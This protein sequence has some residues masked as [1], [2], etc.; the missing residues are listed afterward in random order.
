MITFSHR[1]RLFPD[2]PENTLDSFVNLNRKKGGSVEFDV[3][4]TKD[5]VLVIVHD[6]NTKR[7][8]DKNL[9]ISKSDYSE[10]SKIK[11]LKH[12]KIP[13]LLECLDALSDM[14]II[15]I[16][17]KQKKIAKELNELLINYFRNNP[18]FKPKILISSRLLTEIRNINLDERIQT[19]L[20]INFSALVRLMLLKPRPSIIIVN[21][22]FL[23]PILLKYCKKKSIN[24][25]CYT[26]NKP[27]EF[28]RL[29]ELKV[30]GLYTDNYN[31]LSNL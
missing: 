2:D 24:I 1:G 28:E 23:N 4:K 26:V 25:F 10:I 14:N 20:I 21:R 16:E 15:N 12:Y 7:L 27:N 6:K 29:K 8:S 3:R 17:I 19:G 22:F 31:M 13:T 18:N 30:D 11:V 9:S 5:N